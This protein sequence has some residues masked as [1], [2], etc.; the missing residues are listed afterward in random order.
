MNGRVGGDVIDDELAVDALNI[1]PAAARAGEHRGPGVWPEFERADAHGG[2][3]G[4]GVEPVSVNVPLPILVSLPL[5][6]MTPEKVAAV[7]LS[8]TS[9]PLLDT[10]PVILPPEPPLPICSVPAVIATG[11]V[12][13]LRRL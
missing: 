12:M 8:N 4:I 3:A 6:L 1:R 10:S 9:V 5:P 7:E 2:K 11:Q 13:A